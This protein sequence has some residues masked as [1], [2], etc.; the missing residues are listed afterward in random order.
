M[1]ES[2]SP[3]IGGN[4]RGQ[5]SKSQKTMVGAYT[6][7]KRAGCTVAGTQIAVRGT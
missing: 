4:R 3:A 6:L 5:W 7:A 2:L 1:E